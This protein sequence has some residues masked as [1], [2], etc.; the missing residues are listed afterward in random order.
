[1]YCGAGCMLCSAVCRPAACHSL[2]CCCCCCCDLPH[3]AALLAV[4]AGAWDPRIA[5][6]IA[7]PGNLSA[8]TPH[9]FLLPPCRDALEH[10]QYDSNGGL[11][12][13]LPV[14]GSGEAAA[15]SGG[16]CSRRSCSSQHA[17]CYACGSLFI[18]VL[19]GQLPFA[20]QWWRSRRCTWCTWLWRWRPSARCAA[21]HLCMLV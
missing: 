13:H 19:C 21:V 4:A 20:L 11:D 9:A 16:V 10:G 7:S 15:G 12:Y 17:G 1:M 6:H 2:R 8:A 5:Q 14:E 18:C 3:V